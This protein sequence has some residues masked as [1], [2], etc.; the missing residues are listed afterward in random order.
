M[1]LETLSAKEC[2]SLKYLD[3]SIHP[4]CIGECYSLKELILDDCVYLKEI[5]GLLPN[6][7]NFSAKNC[8]S[9]TSRCTS[10]LLNQESVEA[11]NK[12]FS[13]PGT[14]I[15]DWFAHR[16]SGESV[17][18][19]FRNKFPSISVCLVIGLMDEQLTTV[20]FSPRVFINGNKQFLG[21]R[22]VCEFSISTDH[23]L[24]FDIKLLKFEDNMD[25]VLS[26]KWNRME[27]SY[28]DH[29]SNLM[30]PIKLVAKYSGIH[31]FKQTSGM[32]DIQFTNPPQ[33]M[34][35]ES[36]D[37]DSMEGHRRAMK[38]Q[39][40]VLSSPILTSTRTP[41]SK[42]EEGLGPR[43]TPSAV[44]PWEDVGGEILESLPDDEVHVAEVL[45]DPPVLERCEGDDTELEVASSS[46]LESE[47][48][49]SSTGSD[50]DDP[51]NWVNR[52]FSV[53]GKEAMSSRAIS[54]DAS[55]ASIRE[56]IHGLEL[57]MVKDLSEVHSD[58]ATQSQLD[59]FLDLL[60]RS[61]YHKV[62][63]EVK[64][65]LVEFRRKAFA[66]FQE[67]QETIESVNKLKNFE[68][69][70]ARI[71]KEVLAGKDRRKDLKNS[72]KKASLTIKTE[73]S[74]KKELEAEIAT[75]RKELATKE[76][77]L[78]Q[79][80]LNVKNLEADLSAYMKNCDAL[81]EQALALSKEVDYLLTTN[82]GIE[83]EGKAAEVKQNLL[84]STWST[85][86]A[87]QLSKIKNNIL[88]LSE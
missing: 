19:W 37:S 25:V 56:A 23:V 3:L 6:L 13:L 74:R 44:R 43:Q 55:Q 62:T 54:G 63:V 87:S 29:I 1:K 40:M 64:E 77:D 69:Q 49:F 58:P 10:V 4:E 22:K 47:K 38:D 2:R 27:V 88:G 45:S 18:F 24:L 41:P 68:N 30:F 83:E 66:S 50:S 21:S 33:A 84:N 72:I 80:V 16:T 53:N 82:I 34:I 26:D 7:D 59:N 76:M 46:E 17:S 11:G 67:F 81:N 61:N 57:L 28:A 20:K 14:K 42:A 35:N 86:L 78:E 15:P 70:K 60:I 52:K 73:N 9:L 75:L 5:R 65:A 79:L 85:D 71:Q 12:M 8:T 39:R 48:S 36:S 31:I 51:F 32:E